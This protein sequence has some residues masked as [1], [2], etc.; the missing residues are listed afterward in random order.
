MTQDYEASTRSAYRG[1][2]VDDYKRHTRGLRWGRFTMWREVRI[3]ER[4]MRHFDV[5]HREVMLDAPCGAGI[6][7]VA[8]NSGAGMVVGLDISRDMMAEAQKEYSAHTTAMLVQ[9]DLTCLPLVDGAVA[10][11]VVLG[12]MHRVPP[13]VRADSIREICRVTQRF[14][15]ISFTV[16]SVA[17]RLKRRIL[18]LFRPTHHFAPSPL[19]MQGILDLC[20]GAGF[21]VCRVEH[22]LRPLSGEAVLWL[23]KVGTK[24]A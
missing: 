6:S 23:E 11:T 13:E 21:R 3:V 19:S 2:K 10:G 15:A 18:P 8:M 1:S 4:A 9:G 24:A 12:F 5:K 7:A 14:A 16:D 17:Q 20:R 22:V